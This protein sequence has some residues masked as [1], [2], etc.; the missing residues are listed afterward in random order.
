MAWLLRRRWRRWPRDFP[1]PPSAMELVDSRRAPA[2]APVPWIDVLH[3]PAPAH[4]EVAAVARTATALA[5]AGAPGGAGD[6]RGLPR[7]V[8]RRAGRDPVAVDRQRDRVGQA[9]VLAVQVAERAA[10]PGRQEVG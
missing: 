8:E 5:G 2:Q 1:G 7:G 3:V 9:E 6:L 10:Q 4:H